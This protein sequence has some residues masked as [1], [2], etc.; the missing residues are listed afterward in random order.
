MHSQILEEKQVIPPV[1]WVAPDHGGLEH[2]DLS[3]E[4]HLVSPLGRMR[5]RV[6]ILE[7]LHGDVIVYRRGDWMKLG[8]GANRLIRAGL[9]DIG[10]G[11]PYYQQCVRLENPG[12][13]SDATPS[14]LTP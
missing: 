4:V 10:R 1:V 2:L 9:T 6:E 14:S 8:G 12:E 13:A 3:R 11:A 7:G 5:V